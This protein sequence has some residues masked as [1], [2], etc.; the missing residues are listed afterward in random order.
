MKR[1]QPS[2]KLKL[3]S[4]KHLRII[5]GQWR[6]RRFAFPAV[7]GLRPS[8]DRI[9]ETLFNWLAASVPGS[10][11]LDLFAGS[12]ALGLEALSRG[13]HKLL[14]IELNP[15]ASQAIQQHIQTLEAESQAQVLNQSALDWLNTSAQTQTFDIIFLDPPFDAELIPKCL[16]LIE[17]Q[18]LLAPQ[19]HIYFEAKRH[20]TLGLLPKNWHISKHKHTS[21]LQFGLISHINNS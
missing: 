13:A 8:G 17:Q 6:S 12:G 7:E 2:A 3:N 18:Q 15:T 5:A 19:G 4:Q 9:R 20:Q 1:H 21:Q 10:N 16:D 14:A 11:C